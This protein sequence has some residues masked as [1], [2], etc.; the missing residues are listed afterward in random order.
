MQNER[1]G[2]GGGRSAEADAVVG[3][4]LA[5]GRICLV[6]VMIDWAWLAPRSINAKPLGTDLAV[7]RLLRT[8]LAG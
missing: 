8:W 2:Q 1:M 5:L 7:V 3:T 6:A 4:G